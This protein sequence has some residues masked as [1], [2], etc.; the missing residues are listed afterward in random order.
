MH[1]MM[2]NVTVSFQ[3]LTVS[4]GESSRGYVEECGQPR[5]GTDEDR[6]S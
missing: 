2:V 1:E 4:Q 6:W 3:L 5:M